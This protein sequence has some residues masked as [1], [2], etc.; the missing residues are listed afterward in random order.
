MLYEVIT[1]PAVGAVVDGQAE[2]RQVVGVHHPVDEADPLPLD[3]Q[4]RGVV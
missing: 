4:P 2:D 3:D 1:D